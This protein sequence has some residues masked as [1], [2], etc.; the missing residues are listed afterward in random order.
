MIR[1]SLIKAIISQLLVVLLVY[2]AY[3]VYVD[4]V[5]PRYLYMGMQL[6]GVGLYKILMHGVI[7]S[8][9]VYLLPR[10]LML[11][12]DFLTIF[13][14]IFVVVP[15]FTVP[16]YTATQ[17]E[18]GNYVIYLSIVTVIFILLSRLSTYKVYVRNSPFLSLHLNRPV[19]V[20]LTLMAVGGGAVFAAYG[21]NISRLFQL[22]NVSELYDIR[23][24]FRAANIKGNVIASYALPWLGKA[25]VP[26][27]V[28]FFISKKSYTPIAMLFF[29]QFLL[30]SVS[31][32]KS[33]F[34]GLII[35]PLV[36]YYSSMVNGGEKIFRSVMIAL[37]C[38]IMLFYLFQVEVFVD[39]LLRR[40]FIVPGLLTGYYV[41]YYSLNAF[42]GYK[43]LNSVLVSQGNVLSAPFEI[44][45]FY[46]GRAE[47]AAN[48]NIFA[49]AFSNFGFFGMF[50]E[51]VVLLVFMFFLNW[52]A[53]H[54]DYRVVLATT[55]VALSSMIDSRLFTV[56][57]TH[58]VF[59]AF[60]ISLLLVK[61]SNEVKP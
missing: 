15:A 51:G 34:M 31:G 10:R 52:V 49:S 54:R 41:E 47:L 1:L 43:T 20:A 61:K 26:F 57:L 32:H 14:F 36:Y 30:F 44:G 3:M 33:I 9:G 59:F 11:P 56:L 4:Y 19:I 5:Q 29:F 55:A 37:I 13:I 39:V 45:E 24:D 35:A 60:L 22:S 46:M 16:L 27:L 40:I 8:F 58:G 28:A 21:I 50:F 23:S 12:S 53:V 2:L 6:H 17:L 48:A 18:Y 7:A 25:L 38:M 42:E